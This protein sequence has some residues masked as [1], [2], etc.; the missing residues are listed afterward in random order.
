MP[1]PDATPQTA[2]RRRN[3]VRWT[4][5]SLGVLLLGLVI[6]HGPILRAVVHAVAVKVASGQN[7]KLD[8]RVEGGVL[9]GIT[10]RN[11]HATATGPSAV[12]SLEADRIHAEYSLPDL[13]FHG[14]SDFLK[15]VEV[16]DLT[17]VLDPSKAPI[18]T[19]TPPRPNEK[20][21]LPNFFPKRLQLANVN[22]TLKGQP[23]DT[24]IKNLNIGLFPNQEGKLRIDRLQIPGVHNWSD[25]T[26]TTTYANKNLYLHNLV[27]DREN[28]LETVNIDA[29]QLG[30]G[31][32]G[33]RFNG[34]L[35]GGEVAS[36]I[37][38]TTAGTTYQA[39]TN[40]HAK[41]IS[42]GKLA[43]YLG[44]SPGAFLGDV[45]NA[46]IDLKGSLDQPASWDGTI[47]ANVRNVRQG[48]FALD[49]VKLDAVAHDGKATIRDARIDSGTNHIALRGRV[50]L[51][52]T[53]EGFGRTPGNFQVSIDAPDLKT[54]TGFLDP[55]V[56]GALQGNGTLTTNNG[57]LKLDLQAT[58]DSI[59]QGPATVKQLTAKI[60]ATRKLPPPEEKNAPFFAGLTSHVQTELSDLRYG[61][62]AIDQVT[63]NVQSD[64]ANVT[65][66]P[67]VATRQQNVLQVSGNFQLPRPNEELLK[68]PADLQCNC[69]R[70]S[71]ATTGKGMRRTKSRA[72]AGQRHGPGRDGMASGQSTFSARRS[73][74]KSWW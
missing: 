49:D 15:N 39:N 2:N 18:P 66:A 52:K 59:A 44:K 54:L 12:R 60:S 29:S 47:N 14:M 30:Q 17:A 42:L 19:P 65:L 21:S 69:A 62:Y 23:Q 55:P 71:S 10:L 27:L 8:L 46:D 28:R 7:L 45:Q 70:R 56:T 67:L 1:N 58:G 24:V 31:K 64:G 40:V 11:V 33:L 63:A 4:L 43:E 73:L 3:W 37:E 51:P 74:R 34:T 5:I 72:R 35:S 26:A 57:V 61:D 20:V 53:S 16:R 22:L 68:Q 13:A 6:F 36:K 48:N 50:D 25:V 32:V 41:N 38:V 9:G